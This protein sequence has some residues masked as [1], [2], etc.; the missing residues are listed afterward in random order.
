MGLS[1]IQAAGKNSEALPCGFVYDVEHH[2]IDALKFNSGSTLPRQ[3]TGL[4]VGIL[5]VLRKVQKIPDR[6]K[7][8]H[9]KAFGFRGKA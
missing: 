4:G 1:N 9:P 7:E 6:V 8:K 2:K 5:D 3:W